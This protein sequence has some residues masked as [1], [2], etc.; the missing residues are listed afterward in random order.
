MSCPI[1]LLGRAPDVEAVMSPVWPAYAWTYAA[2][3]PSRA[4]CRGDQG[5]SNSSVIT[6]GGLI[7]LLEVMPKNP[8]TTSPAAVVVIDGATKARPLGVN[9]PL[10]ESTGADTSIP[11]T[12]AID[13]A[14]ETD[15]PK[16]Q[17]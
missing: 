17:L 11:R 12:S 8:R 14:T 7:I 16:V 15:E 13:P 9:A 3:S 5:A 4:H 6:P 10:C 2:P 1:A